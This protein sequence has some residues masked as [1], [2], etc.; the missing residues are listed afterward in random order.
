[1]ITTLR[2]VALNN[3]NSNTHDVSEVL[4][5]VMIACV[6]K[7]A[8]CCGGADAAAG[9]MVAAVVVCPYQGEHCLSHRSRTRLATTQHR[10]GHVLLGRAQYH[11]SSS[12]FPG[13]IPLCHHTAAAMGFS[14]T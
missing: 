10:H 13:P 1:M 5:H 12:W 9:N 7:A 2:D 8:A 3:N 11:H 4:Q 14:D 6:Q